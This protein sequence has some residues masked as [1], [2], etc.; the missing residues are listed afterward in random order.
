MS[1][2]FLGITVLGDYIVSEGSE[3]VLENLLRVGAT[4]VACNPTVTAPASEGTGTFQPPVD[5][6]SS[7]RTFDR[8]LFGETA[9]WL[10]S[11]IS[12]EPRAELYADSPYGP[13]RANDLRADRGH[14]IGEFV[15]SARGAGLEVYFQIGAV[16]PTGLRDEDRPRLPNGQLPS[17]RL[18][19][20][21]SL[22]SPAVRAYNRAYA[23][24]LFAEYP[25][26]TGLRIDWP[27]Y[28]CYTLG[29]VFQGFEPHVET[30]C[31]DREFDFELARTETAR[32]WD[33]LHGNLTDDHLAKVDG[34]PANWP[35]IEGFREALRIRAALSADLLADWKSIM[36]EVAG[37]EAILAAN[38]FPPPYSRLTGIEALGRD[39]VHTVP[40]LAHC[41]AFAMKLY[42]MHW[43][44]MIEFWGR[45]LLAANPG[46]TDERR[47][48][49]VLVRLLDIDEL[50][51]TRSA[52]DD[53]GYPEPDEPHPVPDGPQRRK[54]AHLDSLRPPTTAMHVLVHGYGPVDDFERRLRLAW[55]AGTDGVWINRYG[56]LGD[57][58]LDVVGE[59]HSA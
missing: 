13:R 12:F 15:T 43:S 24:D 54:I 21:A 31:A 57:P 5:A 58:K 10:R 50:G 18:A 51:S 6:G 41:D 23:R 34:T 59:L 55:D 7:K 22:A 38:T 2:R 36:R 27:E 42:T 48:V 29:E 9:L 32:L 47:L 11:G 30:W 25:E 44:Q 52:I 46:L 26:L 56:Y 3:T 28:P 53:W 8:P 37:P 33:F 39:G 20:T 35:G 1:D 45:E 17:G 4:A 14:L 49:D 19:D 40:G 16:Q